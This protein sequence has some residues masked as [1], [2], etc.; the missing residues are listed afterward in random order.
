ML[1]DLGA[2]QVEPGHALTGTTPLHAVRDLVEAP[3]ALYLTEVSHHHAG[4]AFCFGGGLYVDPVFPEYPT[5]ALAMRE[6]SIRS[7]RR[8]HAEIP[9][10]SMI[11]YYAMLTSPDG[12]L[13]AVGETIIFGYRI[14]A[15]VTRA[16]VVPI[17][18]IASGNPEVAGVFGSDGR[19]AAWPL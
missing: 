14:Q 15:F 13:P 10:P 12:W 1:A 7:A 6:P 16:F 17:R 4:E 2:T 11:D 9:P 3:A 19:P 18:G 5:Q 8:L